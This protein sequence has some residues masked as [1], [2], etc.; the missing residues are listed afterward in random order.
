MN[1]VANEESCVVCTAID[2]YVPARSERAVC[3]K[4]N[5]KS[6]IVVERHES[7]PAKLMEG[8]HEINDV[9]DFKAVLSLNARRSPV[10]LEAETAV[11]RVHKAAIKGYWSNS[12]RSSS[13]GVNADSEDVWCSGNEAKIDANNMDAAT[14][15]KYRSHIFY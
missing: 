4:A 15:E 10:R 14:A 5:V 11:G 1:V 3:L 2:V 12:S 13:E 7:C 8:L 9:G 6:P